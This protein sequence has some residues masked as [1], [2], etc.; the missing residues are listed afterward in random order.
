MGHGSAGKSTKSICDQSNLD[1]EA[2][3]VEFFR[4]EGLTVIEDPDKEAFA[5]YARWSYQNESPDISEPWDWDL[6]DRIQDMK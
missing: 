4:A 6:Y 3:L 1:L 2:E 5:D